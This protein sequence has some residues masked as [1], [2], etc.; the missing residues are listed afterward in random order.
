MGGGSFNWHVCIAH[1]FICDKVGAAF[2]YG[3]V[4][5][6]GPTMSQVSGRLVL[7]YLAQKESHMLA[8]FWLHFARPCQSFADTTC[9]CS[10]VFPT[11]ATIKNALVPSQITTMFVVSELAPHPYLG[12][13]DQPHLVGCSGYVPPDVITWALKHVKDFVLFCDLPCL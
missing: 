9:C 13:S 1:D 12:G 8:I 7:G 11:P 6:L 2:W 10:G 5:G 3:D 4:V